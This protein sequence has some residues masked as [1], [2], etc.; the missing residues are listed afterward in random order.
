MLSFLLQYSRLKEVRDALDVAITVMQKLALDLKKVSATHHV[1][2][3][4]YVPVSFL[5]KACLKMEEIAY[6]IDS[7]SSKL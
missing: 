4:D 2:D 7:T 1:A 5:S 6:I 3:K